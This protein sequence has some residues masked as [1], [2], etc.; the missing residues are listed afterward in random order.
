MPCYYPISAWQCL[1]KKTVNGKPSISF[2]NPF[3]KANANRVALQLPCGQCI[4]CRLERSRQWAIRCCHEA[5][6]YDDNCF[7]TLTYNDKNLPKGSTLVKKHFQNFMKNLR[8]NL[9]RGFEYYDED[10]KEK[11]LPE[12]KKVRYYQCGEYGSKKMRP[13]YHACLF[14]FDFPDRSL[15]AVRDG[16]KLYRSASL[17][18]LWPYGFSTVGNVTFE[19]AAYVARY[20]TKKL[21]GEKAVQAYRD[22]SPE[23]TTMSRRPGIGKGWFDKYKS[24]VYPADQVILRGKDLRPPRY[25]DKL[26]DVDNVV[27]MSTI[28]NKRKA[29]AVANAA[30]NTRARLKVKE[31]CKLAQFNQLKRGFENET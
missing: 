19:S 10:D 13:H 21:T 2:N 1:D 20:I 25:Y 24:D 15:Y 18:K 6:L 22:R 27:G 28:K 29:Q 16:C 3:G 31:T 12:G 4:G 17:E 9:E 26:Y 7:I 5:S 23:Y 30:D 8:I 11:K 14:G